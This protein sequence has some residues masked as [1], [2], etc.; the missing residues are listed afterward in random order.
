[1]RGGN[2]DRPVKAPSPT[3]PQPKRCPGCRRPLCRRRCDRCVSENAWAEAAHGW[4]WRGLE[5]LDVRSA[6]AIR[7]YV[8]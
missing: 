7:N 1:M 8:S 4:L 5:P 6:R 2:T 3:R